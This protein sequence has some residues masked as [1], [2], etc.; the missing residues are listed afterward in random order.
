M[1]SRIAQLEEQV[2]G[3][4]ANQ[5]ARK[6]PVASGVENLKAHLAV[7]KTMHPGVDFTA[8]QERVDKLPE[9]PDEVT[10]N[11][12]AALEHALNRVHTTDIHYLRE[13]GSD[14][15]QAVLNRTADK[16]DESE[17]DAD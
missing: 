2:A 8:V 5:P 7:Q 4:L 13:L 11:H 16:A 15:H 6:D 17:T 12:T 14:L 3:L 9:N 10:A 1:A